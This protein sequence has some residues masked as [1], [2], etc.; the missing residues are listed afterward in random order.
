[1]CLAGRRNYTFISERDDMENLNELAAALAKA[2]GVIQPAPKDADNP[3][4]KSKYASLPAVREAMRQAFADN[5]LSVIQMPGVSDGQLK[6]RTVLLHSSGQSLDC[7]TLSADVDIL[8]PQKIGSAITYFRRYALAAISQTVADEDD[9]A[10]AATKG[11]R[12]NAG[13][14]RRKPKPPV[15]AEGIAELELAINDCVDDKALDL[16]IR[17]GGYQLLKERGPADEYKRIAKLAQDTYARLKVSDK[18]DDVTDS[19]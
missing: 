1:M 17:D 8:N 5:G 3:Y 12:G 13:S 14:P 4:F 18:N 7:G 16:L 9:D 2:Q 15:S 11:N 10:N 19:K 6:L